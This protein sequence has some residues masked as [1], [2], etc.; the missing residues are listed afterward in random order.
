MARDPNLNVIAFTPTVDKPV[1]VRSGTKVALLLKLMQRKNG[2]TLQEIAT[3]LSEHGGSKCTISYA[4]SWV[5][6][7][8]LGSLGYGVRSK[9]DKGGQLR[10]W[11]YAAST[12]ID[13]TRKDVDTSAKARRGGRRN[14][15]AKA[16]A[17]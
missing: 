15:S 11:A 14:K 3:E 7:S 10:V 13:N 5:A 6:R 12:V 8:Y 9:H 2:V 17:A 1:A 4:R 16:V